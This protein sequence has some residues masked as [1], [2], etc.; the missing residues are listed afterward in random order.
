M[1]PDI[2]KFQELYHGDREIIQV[3]SLSTTISID[4]ME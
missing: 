4:T 2:P 1:I 3:E